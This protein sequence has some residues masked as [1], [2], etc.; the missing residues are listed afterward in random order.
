MILFLASEQHL[1][2]HV[3]P[4]WTPALHSLNHLPVLPLSAAQAAC[5]SEH[6]G[7]EAEGYI[8]VIRRTGCVSD[9]VKGVAQS[10]AWKQQNKGTGAQ[11]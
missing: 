4:G 5:A 3:L 7:V 1:S 10:T 6:R 8:S 2:S 9:S 11:Q